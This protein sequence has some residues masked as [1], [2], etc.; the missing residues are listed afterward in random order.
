MNAM[1]VIEWVWRERSIVDGAYPAKM[2]VANTA[3]LR[4]SVKLEESTGGER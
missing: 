2:L 1:I 4:A 3:R